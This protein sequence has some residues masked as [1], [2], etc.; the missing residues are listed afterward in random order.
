MLALY[1]HPDSGGY[2]ERHCH[3]HLVA[4]G[5]HEVPSWRSCYVHPTL[6]L[7]LV[8]YVDDFKLAGPKTSLAEGWRMIRKQ[9]RTEDPIPLGKYLGCNHVVTAR[10]LDL[11]TDAHAPF[12]W[13]IPRVD[14]VAAFPGSAR[15][16]DEPAPTRG[17]H[18][19]RENNEP[20]PPCGGGSS[21]GKAGGSNGRVP[22]KCLEYD[23]SDFLTSCLARYQE[24]SPRPVVFRKVDTPFIDESNLGDDEE[25]KGELAPIAARILMKLLYAARMCRFDLLRPCCWLAT[26]ITKWG[27]TCDRALHRLMCYVHSTLNLKLQAWIGDPP[28]EWQF[29]VYSDADF[30]G[31]K[32]TSRSTT[33]VFACIRAKNTFFPLTAISKRQSCVSH[34]TP[35]AE[36]V[37]ADHA[38]RTTGLP[39]LQL[40]EALLGRPLQVMFMEDNEATIRIIS[41]GKSQ[42]MRHVGRTHRVDLAFLHEAKENKHIIVNPC[43]TDYMCA[44]IFTKTFSNKQKWDQVTR[45][46]AHVDPQLFWLND[47]N[48]RTPDLLPPQKVDP[49]GQKPTGGDSS[50]GNK[51]TRNALPSQMNVEVERRENSPRTIVEFCCGPDSLIGRATPY[52]KGCRIIRLTQEEDVTSEKGL[53]IALDAVDNPDV[54]LWGSLPCTGGSAWQRINKYRPGGR[55]RLRQHYSTFRKMWK[56]FE[57]VARITHDKGG[58]LLLSGPSIAVIG[59]GRASSAY[60]KNCQCSRFPFMVARLG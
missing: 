37:A 23:M 1:G 8:V 44:D 19:S 56:S 24:L 59:A 47:K 40:W 16:D 30:A 9:V 25:T 33:G 4:Q 50:V 14:K 36:I 54:L 27:K 52:S 3:K 58:A 12:Q 5:F 10:T 2:W 34:S 13:P 51:G 32:S 7:F 43:P 11:T 21:R 20:K 35:E 39:G 22:V 28:S 41:T 18:S 31:D 38:V 42:A 17:G 15:G 60:L 26:Q 57:Q 46:I 49:I 55:T 45:L 29:V 6:R 53:A 48:R